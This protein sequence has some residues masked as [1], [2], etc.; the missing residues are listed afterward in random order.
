MARP[1]AMAKRAGGPS[2]CTD[3]LVHKGDP[4]Q[5]TSAV[6]IKAALVPSEGARTPGDS[7]RARAY[8]MQRHSAAGPV[9]RVSRKLSLQSRVWQQALCSGP[10]APACSQGTAVYR[11]LSLTGWRHRPSSPAASQLLP[12]QRMYKQAL[13]WQCSQQSPKKGNK[14]TQGSGACQHIHWPA[15]TMHHLRRKCKDT[16]RSSHCRPHRH[17]ALPT[18]AMA[19]QPLHNQSLG[20]DPHAHNTH[21]PICPSCTHCL[22]MPAGR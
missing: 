14:M 8:F 1:R 6:P 15:W 22:V 20:V 21:R 12:I 10:R 4:E 13:W 5:S 7:S 3:A 19:A 9:L 16:W 2:G 17:N 18:Q 11:S